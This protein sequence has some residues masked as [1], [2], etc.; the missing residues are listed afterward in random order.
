MISYQISASMIA[1]IKN[2]R[3]DAGAFTTAEAGLRAKEDPALRS[4]VLEPT[5]Q[6]AESQRESEIVLLLNKDATQLTQAL[7]EDIAG[8]LADGTV[9]KALTTNGIDASFA[10]QAS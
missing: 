10:A 6:I 4:A 8:M 9:S 1:D 5:P 7:N 2:G 3:V